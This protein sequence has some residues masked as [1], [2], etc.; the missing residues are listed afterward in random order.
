MNYLAWGQKFVSQSIANFA[1][2]I[3]VFYVNGFLSFL[4]YY[5]VL[6]MD[7]V[8]G[9]TQVY[10]EFTGR[11]LILII[12]T[13]LTFP[14]VL[15]RNKVDF[16]WGGNALILWLIITL[17]LIAFELIANFY[18][19]PKRKYFFNNNKLPSLL[20]FCALIAITLP[21]LSL[22][23][24]VAG[25]RNVLQPFDISSFTEINSNVLRIQEEKQADNSLTKKDMFRNLDKFAEKIITHSKAS[26][27]KDLFQMNAQRRNLD[28]GDKERFHAFMTLILAITITIILLFVYASTYEYQFIEIILIVFIISQVLFVPFLYGALGRE[29]K[30]P[31]VSFSYKDIND[32][33]IKKEGVIL[34]ETTPE[35]LIIYDRLNFFRISYVSKRSI[36]NVQKMFVI[37]PFSNCSEERFKPCELYTLQ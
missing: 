23:T 19:K 9:S 6:G 25:I 27:V 4:A 29:Y 33:I 24:Q 34:L 22:E 36:I 3:A 26:S 21:I 17:S 37:S 1:V 18:L 8:E 28:G 15:F 32:A 11:S 7:N 13:F 2:V 14:F 30:Y 16:G 12:Q 10:A 5:R 20:C 35:K 31:V